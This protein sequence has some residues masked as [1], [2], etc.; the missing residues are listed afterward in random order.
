M[1][2]YDS[3][4]GQPR[5]PDLDDPPI[6]T[7]RVHGPIVCE[8]ECAVCDGNH[9]WMEDAVD[10]DDLPDYLDNAHM[11]P[12]DLILSCKHCAAWAEYPEW[13]ADADDI[14]WEQIDVRATPKRE[15]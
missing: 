10:E 7:L 15:E 5:S 13:W 4:G 3:R 12:N 11:K 9:H 14:E 2:T 6:P 1:G 8:R